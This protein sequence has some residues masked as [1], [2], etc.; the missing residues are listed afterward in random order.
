MR[1]DIMIP[2]KTWD[3]AKE[4]FQAY[5]KETKFI[6]K[7]TYPYDRNDPSVLFFLTKGLV[8]EIQLQ[9]SKSTI[10]ILESSF[11]KT[12]NGDIFALKPGECLGQG[13]F[14]KVKIAQNNAD[15]VVAIKIEGVPKDAGRKKRKEKTQKVEQKIL[16]QLG[17]FKGEAIRTFGQP[18]SFSNKPT[19]FCAKRYLAQTLIQG[20]ELFKDIEWAIG[21]NSIALIP[22]PLR[23]KTALEASKAIKKLHDNNIIHGDIKPENFM[24]NVEN[25]RIS[26]EVI[27]FGLSSILKPGQ[28]SVI[29]VGGTPEYIAPEVVTFKKNTLGEFVLTASGGPIIESSDGNQSFASDIYSLGMV[30]GKDLEV[31]CDLVTDM[32]DD[33]PAN[34]PDINTVIKTLKFELLDSE[35]CLLLQQKPNL[36]SSAFY[37]KLRQFIDEHLDLLTQNNNAE[38]LAIKHA[39]D[40]PSFRFKDVI[41][42]KVARQKLPTAWSTRKIITPLQ[43]GCSQVA[44]N[45]I[46]S[47]PLCPKVRVGCN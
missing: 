33:D 40:L 1:N 30:I 47:P 25:N 36:S 23:I 21:S 13:A 28:T 17:R 8:T 10:T 19:L 31:N 5:P 44:A 46:G 7:I 6:R 29:R 22:K 27:D 42:C 18:K 4:F 2:K 14:G 43:I 15:E 11:I 39:S 38:R 35:M 32:L 20:K 37:D 16:T 12:Q 3:L 9:A 26:V 34:R 41:A 24:I 45:V